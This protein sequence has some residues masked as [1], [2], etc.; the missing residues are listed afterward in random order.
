MGNRRRVVSGKELVGCFS[1]KKF[2]QGNVLCSL[3]ATFAAENKGLGT[4]N[5]FNNLIG[6][7]R[8][9]AWNGR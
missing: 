7:C 5:W 6:S 8:E 9:V 3:K 1:K 4:L 2:Y